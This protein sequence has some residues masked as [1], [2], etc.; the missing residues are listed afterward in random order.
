MKQ[1]D[2]TDTEWRGLRALRAV[3][4]SL[5]V[6]KVAFELFE[7]LMQVLLYILVATVAVQ[8][9]GL[10]CGVTVNLWLHFIGAPHYLVLA[11]AGLALY[12]VARWHQLCRDTRK[13]FYEQE[14]EYKG[15]RRWTANLLRYGCPH[16][17]HMECEG[18]VGAYRMY[19]VTL[20]CHAEGTKSVVHTGVAHYADDAV[21][22]CYRAAEKADHDSCY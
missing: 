18:Q 11:I 15:F 7:G 3:G 1:V 4:K 6:G 12:T 8:V 19:T 5:T 16:Y 17:L 20:C 10:F 14:S 13:Q 9:V 22:A 21:L 2:L